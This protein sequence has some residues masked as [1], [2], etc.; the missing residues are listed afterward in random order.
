M[1]D[2]GTYITNDNGHANLRTQMYGRLPEAKMGSSLGGPSFMM[3]TQ[4]N[5]R[6]AITHR[7]GMES[8]GPGAYETNT[9]SV[10]NFNFVKKAMLDK[11]SKRNL[12]MNSPSGNYS[13]ASTTNDSS[14]L[15]KGVKPKSK[16][17]SIPSIPSR[18]LTPVLKF[19]LQE[20]DAEK[21][22]NKIL[23]AEGYNVFD[24]QV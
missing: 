22:L 13:F 2:R 21:K 17:M 15:F 14:M 3:Q 18:F 7:I 10:T 9:S 1:D 24:G 6:M 20:K 23:E 16:N 5:S 8:P 4:A 11:A 19:D 12:M